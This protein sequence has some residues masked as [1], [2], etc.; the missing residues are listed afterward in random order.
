MIY[1]HALLT[2]AA[3]DGEKFEQVV[4][5]ARAILLEAPGCREV[6]VRRSIDRPG[7][8]LLRVCWD[9]LD[10]HQK[11]FPTTPQAARLSDL[12]GPFFAAEPQVI[13]FAAEE[14]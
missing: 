9:R 4:P 6:R 5:H 3:A 11:V 12:I 1:E 13:H 2:I 7:V 8:Y 10:D 14:V